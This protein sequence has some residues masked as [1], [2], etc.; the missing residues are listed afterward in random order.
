MAYCGGIGALARESYETIAGMMK[1]RVPSSRN[2]YEQAELRIELGKHMLELTRT[3]AF[4]HLP[5]HERQYVPM[6][7]YVHK[8][9]QPEL[10]DLLFL[11]ADYERM[12]DRFEV[13]F[14]LIHADCQEAESSRVWGPVGR[15]GWKHTPLLRIIEE[16]K[17]EGAQWGPLRVG[18]FDAS[19][20]RFERISK[21]YFG[22]IGKLGWI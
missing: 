15:F 3:D 8:L 13:L 12:F 19:Y 11:G 2:I 20:E 18:F 10:D 4:K 14:A 22:M 21:E 16:A 17:T 9:L 6:S 7:E 1:S 5:G